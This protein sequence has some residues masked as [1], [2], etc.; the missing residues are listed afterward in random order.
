MLDCLDNIIGIDRTCAGETPI[1]GLYVQDL[2]GIDLRVADSVVGSDYASGVRLLKDKIDFAKNLMLAEMRADLGS[3]VKYGTIVENVNIG[4]FSEN[5]T[6]PSQVGFLK[7]IKITVK[8]YPYFELFIQSISVLATEDKSIEVYVY[9]LITGQLLDTIEVETIANQE[10]NVVLGKKYYSQRKSLNLFVCTSSELSSNQARLNKTHCLGCSSSVSNA[11][12]SLSFG[13]IA[14]GSPVLDKNIS[15]GT[16]TGGLSV[17]YSLGCSLEPY[18]CNMAGVLGFPLLYKT[19]YVIMDEA[20]N[21]SRLNGLVLN[22][23]DDWEALRE[24]YEAMYLKS[25][26]S[27]MDNLRL[28]KDICFECNSS[29]RKVVQIP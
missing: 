21:T 23:K 25:M 29:I 9:D 27:L 4:Y 2:S 15:S 26:M 12:T 13:T 22:K 8:D 5:K 18:L 10:V 7:G 11:Y 28:P 1:S 19:G 6:I 3:K 20:V 24:R 14:V 17:S 16:S